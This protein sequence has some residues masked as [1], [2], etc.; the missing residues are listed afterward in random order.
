MNKCAVA[1]KAGTL[2]TVIKELGYDFTVEEFN[3]Y[4]EERVVP[5]SESELE[6]VS[7]GKDGGGMKWWF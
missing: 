5:L 3:A 4:M 1:K 2:D 7:G 6:A